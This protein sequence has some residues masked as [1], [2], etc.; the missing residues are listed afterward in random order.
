[1]RTLFAIFI[2]LNVILVFLLMIHF[3]VFAPRIALHIAAAP[4]HR[5]VAP[6][7]TDWAEDN[8]ADVRITWLDSSEISQALSK[9]TETE[10]DAVWPD[11]SLWIGLGDAGE[12]VQHQASVYRSP[13]ILGLRMSTVIGLGWIGRTDITLS[14]IADAAKDQEFRLTMPAP[15]RSGPGAVAYLNLLRAFSDN[16]E[17]LTPE[18][19]T[20]DALLDSMR[21]LLAQ[22][23][24]APGSAEGLADAFVGNYSA[25]DAMFTTEAQV[26]QTSQRLVAQG[27]EPLYAIYPADGLSL[28][29]SPLGF[30]PKGDEAKEAKFLDLQGF[31][32]SAEVQNQL[33]ASGNRAGPEGPDAETADK[34]LWNPNWGIDAAAR[35]T[36]IATPSVPV[37]RE[38]L[39][40]YQ[41]D[42]R[43]PALTV[44]V[45]DVSDT[46]DGAPMQ[47]LKASA[48][49]LFAAPGANGTALQSDSRDVTILLPFNHNILD[50]IIIEGGN[51]T[52]TER[53][54]SF[55]TT[56]EADGGT[57]LYYA[58]YEAFEA[59]RP[60]AEDG[61]LADYRP[62]FIVVTA[63]A[64][65]TENR[66]PLLAH[67]AETPYTKDI[68]I[69][70]VALGAAD[71]DQLAEL[72]K[73]SAG[74]VFRA[75]NDLSRTLRIAKGGN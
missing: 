50:P 68:P 48:D 74:Q 8:K 38:A 46:M 10:F 15:P 18:D 52:A 4:E 41:N 27:D 30:I 25:F 26:I 67:I 60:Y 1:M 19:L 72:S 7:I 54:K 63:G 36:P 34:T 61:T 71:A 58:L 65:D 40:L 24:R 56:L 43:K 42:L 37:I 17:T 55:V 32:A 31:L 49:A 11:S 69:H 59:V 16:P 5:A 14:E 20:K 3:G 23:D 73:L 39:Q 53:A 22:V 44:W 2:A 9:A 70:T 29:D 6:L 66:I 64:S 33:V 13:V 57:D 75:G 12:V 51:P 28:T 62:A 21:A 45:M 35:F 47:E